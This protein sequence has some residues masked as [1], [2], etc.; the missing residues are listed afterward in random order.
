MPMPKGRKSKN[1]YA[2]V[3]SLS[4]DD[5]KAVAQ[6]CNDLGFKMNH[7]TARNV[8]LHAMAKIACSLRESHGLSTDREATFQ[9]ALNPMFQEGVAEILKE[10]LYK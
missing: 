4:G 8:L 3:S 1:G 5:Y 9:N 2:T 10:K 7:S 6:K